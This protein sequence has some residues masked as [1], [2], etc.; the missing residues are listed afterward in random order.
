MRHKP[1]S[2]LLQLP[3]FQPLYSESQ[4]SVTLPSALPLLTCIRVA[5]ACCVLGLGCIAQV[6]AG[7]LERPAGPLRHMGSPLAFGPAG[8]LAMPRLAQPAQ[9]G[10]AAQVAQVAE[11]AQL[12]QTD[13]TAHLG[14]A[15]WV[16]AVDAPVRP[17]PLSLGAGPGY[18]LR[19][20]PAPTHALATLPSAGPLPA[21][22]AEADVS[23]YPALALGA[24]AALALVGRR[25]LPR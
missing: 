22:P 18:S 2:D 13:P 9:L 1:D 12:V 21:E 8:G 20:S 5:A 3:G 16:A 14:H 7:V 17:G 10:Q 19:R 4:L 11:F 25:R 15:S 24:L 6:Q 23:S